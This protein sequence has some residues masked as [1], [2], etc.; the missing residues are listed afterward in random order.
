MPGKILIVDDN[1]LNLAILEELLSDNYETVSAESGEQ[2][3]SVAPVFKPDLVLLD[4]MM[5]G[6][7]GY[8]TCRWI[9][10]H[11]ELNAIK[12]IMVSAKASPVDIERGLE[13]G[14]DEYITKPFDVD[15]LSESVRKHLEDRSQL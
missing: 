8:E 15:A 11:P 12:V 5:P 6:I 3:I 2:A 4:V 10:A 13:A 1:E 7:D 14:A 9:R